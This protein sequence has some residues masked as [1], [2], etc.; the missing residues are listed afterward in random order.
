MPR[1]RNGSFQEKTLGFQG[2]D[3]FT[4]ENRSLSRERV[5]VFTQVS[6]S[7]DI[8][9]KPGFVFNV[10][11]ARTKLAVDNVK[12]QWSPGGSCRLEHLLKT[13][14]NLPIVLIPLRKRISQFMY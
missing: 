1:Y 8:K 12:D 11:G 13:I 7:S 2:E 9:L 6:S 14:N 5:T 4:K 10:K 3:T